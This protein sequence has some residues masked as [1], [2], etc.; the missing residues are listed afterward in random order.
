M[1]ESGRRAWH[2]CPEALFGLGKGLDLKGLTC[3]TEP[4]KSSSVLT[5]GATVTAR[6]G[7][8]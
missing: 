4:F 5:R 8:S 7:R 1:A 2:G 3:V 6:G